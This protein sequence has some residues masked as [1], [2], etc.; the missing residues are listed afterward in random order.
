MGHLEISA[1][2]VGVRAESIS[3]TKEHTSISVN[4][5]TRVPFR[6]TVFGCIHEVTSDTMHIDNNLK[7]LYDTSHNQLR[8][9]NS[10]AVKDGG[11]QRHDHGEETV[12]EPHCT[13]GDASEVSASANPRH[14]SVDKHSDC[15]V[16]ST[17]H[18]MVV[19]DGSRKREDNPRWWDRVP[20]RLPNGNLALDLHRF[21]LRAFELPHGW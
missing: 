4:M 7:M 10:F 13:H 14:N 15:T 11:R 18:A 12:R 21:R 17:D 3:Q 8:A 6:L 19:T 16:N 1:V 20:F 2:T 9:P 5:Y